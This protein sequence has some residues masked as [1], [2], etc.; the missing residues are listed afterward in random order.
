MEGCAH[1]GNNMSCMFW[2]AFANGKNFQDFVLPV[3]NG[4]SGE[5]DVDLLSW[6][7]EFKIYL[8]SELKTH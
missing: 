1:L 8:K 6:K 4:G 3:K 2:G 7:F 5:G